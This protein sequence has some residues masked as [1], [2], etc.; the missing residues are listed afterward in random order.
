MSRDRSYPRP[1]SLGAPPTQQ[2]NGQDWAIA[3]EDPGEHFVYGPPTVTLA[4]A[5]L[6]P[7]LVPGALQEV[8]YQITNRHHHVYLVTMNSTGAF[9]VQ[10]K[11]GDR[12]IFN[13]PQH[14]ANIFGQGGSPMPF[15]RPL[16]TRVN[17][18]VYFDLQDLSG[19]ANT[20]YIT[21]HGVELRS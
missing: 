13:T 18:I 8:T 4:A 9:L 7:P 21:M 19:A 15:L 12:Y 2:Y 14:S 5:T 17:D 11:V 1:H 6:G 20:V 10:I 3:D 16:R